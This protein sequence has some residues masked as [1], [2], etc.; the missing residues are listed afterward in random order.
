MFR[1]VFV[2]KRL[3]ACSLLVKP[4]KLH[5]SSP[6]LKS[7]FLPFS[8]IVRRKETPPSS[9][10]HRGAQCRD[11]STT[12][13]PLCSFSTSS[14]PTNTVKQTIANDRGLQNFL[15][16]VY[17][18]AGLG[19]GSTLAGASLL[20]V[21]LP[22]GLIMGSALPL[23]GG[24]F[25]IGMAGAVGVDCA[26]YEINDNGTASKNSLGRKVSFGA[27]IVGMTTMT[28]P[29]VPIIH[30]IDPL[31]WPT[32]TILSF[33]TMGVATA[34]AHSRP[35]GALLSWG[36]PLTGGLLLLI[37]N[38]FVAIGAQYFFPASG[39]AEILHSAD[40][41]GG[42]ALFTALTAYQTH[43][44][45]AMYQKGDPDHLGCAASVYLDFLNLL[46]RIAH[47]LAKAKQK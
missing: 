22:A 1:A 39:V 12:S 29:C 8:G 26:K 45:V 36:G 20:T 40:V 47:A 11:K 18:T 23:I 17:A 46:I 13:V 28:L 21:L 6:K 9:F 31:I 4:K 25:L 43:V 34:W 7:P 2:P 16:R 3:A 33:A 14:K 35:A 32:A 10:F 27:L 42:I 38:G 24:G 37:G 44:S 5:H 15:K 41:Y 19:I 30:E